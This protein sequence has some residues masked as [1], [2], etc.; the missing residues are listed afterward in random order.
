MLWMIAVAGCTAGWVD[1]K[2]ED[3]D[4]PP[5]LVE[6]D[7]L[8]PE[9]VEVTLVQDRFVWPVPMI[10]VLFLVDGSPEA[11]AALP[12]AAQAPILQA[13]NERAFHTLAGFVAL[14][15]VV[16]GAIAIFE[17]ARSDSAER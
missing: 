9:T 5:S 14:L 17:R 11:L 13:A 10:D 7:P 16:F 15:I 4:G 3:A 12:A 8:P 2:P 6:E 1:V